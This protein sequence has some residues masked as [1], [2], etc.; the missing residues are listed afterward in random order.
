MR[1]GQARIPGIIVIKDV[2]VVR[3]L[4]TRTDW[5]GPLMHQRVR[6]RERLEERAYRR[7]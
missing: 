3:L 5:L 7:G 2:A 6:R 4:G 1:T